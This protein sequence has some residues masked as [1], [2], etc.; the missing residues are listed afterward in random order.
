MF[1]FPEKIVVVLLYQKFLNRERAELNHRP[2]DL[3]SNALATLPEYNNVDSPKCLVQNNA[4]CLVYK[5][6][7]FF[8]C[9]LS[10]QKYN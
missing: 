4:P 7:R 2:L 5:I 1:D 8:S 10:A 3:Q 9:R 6:E